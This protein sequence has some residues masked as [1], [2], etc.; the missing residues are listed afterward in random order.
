MQSYL[1]C[2]KFKQHS[3]EPYLSALVLSDFKDLAFAQSLIFGSAFPNLGV[4]TVTVHAGMQLF[5]KFAKLFL[6][7][8]VN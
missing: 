3:L 1:I 4:L 2:L 8:A 7:F 6:L 5:T